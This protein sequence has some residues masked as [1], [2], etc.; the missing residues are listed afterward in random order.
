MTVIFCLH[1]QIYYYSLFHCPTLTCGL[2][3]SFHKFARPPRSYHWMEGGGDQDRQC[4]YK[5]NIDTHLRNH[6]CCGKAI[7]I[8]YSSVLSVTLF[9]QHAK[10]MRGI[11]WS[12]VASLALPYFSTLS[13]KRHNFR[14]KKRVIELKMWI[15]IFSTTS[16]SKIPHAKKNSAR[17][18]KCTYVFM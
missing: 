16:L 13:H 15:L 2:S 7:N 8:T 3:L 4:K 12:S 10:R 1:F 5:S 14:K 11:T 6:C 9:T 17:Y 18:H